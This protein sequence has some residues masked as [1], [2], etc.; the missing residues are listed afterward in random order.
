[1][2]RKLQSSFYFDI[3][4]KIKIKSATD[5]VKAIYGNNKNYT[6]EAD[7]RRNQA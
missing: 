1:M 5:L 6:N 2:F 7:R 4:F 3:T